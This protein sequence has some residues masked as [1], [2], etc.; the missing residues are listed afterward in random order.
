MFIRVTR[1]STRRSVLYMNPWDS[2]DNLIE[3]SWGL[4][5]YLPNLSNSLLHQAIAMAYF[6]RSV[7]N[8]FLN[9]C[10][11]E[12]SCAATTRCAKVNKSPKMVSLLAKIVFMSKVLDSRSNDLQRFGRYKEGQK[13][14]HEISIKLPYVSVLFITTQT[15][16][17]VLS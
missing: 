16:Y 10:C 1:V 17:R 7:N 6:I 15:F 3:I 4:I 13:I 9:V 2:I 14:P 5:L 8:L 12:L 11:C